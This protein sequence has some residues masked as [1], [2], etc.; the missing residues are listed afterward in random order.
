MRDSNHPPEQSQIPKKQ[1]RPPFEC[2]ALLLQG[3]GA[4]G[5]YQAGVYEALFEA[6]LDPD[7]VA[8]ISIGSINAAIIA[9]NPRESRVEM[10]RKFWELVT[11]TPLWV[12]FGLLSSA[13]KNQA[14]QLVDHAIATTASVG[15]IGLAFASDKP[16]EARV[17]ALRAI[18]ENIAGY[19]GW[20]WP[21]DPALFAARGDISRGLANQF[22]AGLALL[23]GAP[24]F[25]TPRL[26]IPWLQPPGTIG[27]TSYYDSAALEATLER[28]VDFDRINA[29]G[30]RL[31]LGAVNLTTGNFVYFDNTTHTIR[32]KHVMA[33]GALPPGFPAVEIEGEHYWDGGLVSN[34][35]LNWV[36]ESE[37]R[38]D[39]LAFQVD[40]WSARGT[41]PRS[42]GEV[43]TRQKEIQYSSRTRANS[44]SF[45]YTQ[46]L[47]RALS[48]L[49][50]KLPEELKDSKEAAALRPAASHKVYNLIQLIYRSKHYE[51]DSK[52]YEF[53][54][55]SMEEHWRAGYHDTVRT[56]RHAEVYERPKS[57]DGVFAF[58]LA[59]DG[60]E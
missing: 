15:A 54:R 7:W 16:V 22:S 49:L 32:P 27:A 51:G 31:S 47:R 3:G 39:M 11:A 38:R 21:S 34:T 29:G 44:D 36:L 19:A 43:M 33:S 4:L 57:I 10:L 12:N 20:I 55:P 1:Q 5:A 28:L 53:S 17:E 42:M 46:K 59:Y 56:L 18:W 23:R 8:G 35:P 24:G 30:M 13:A 48:S 58:D 45:K 37:P 40:L 50:E 41:L 6:N 25:F 60:R 26:P 9:G 14:L 2:I 52:D